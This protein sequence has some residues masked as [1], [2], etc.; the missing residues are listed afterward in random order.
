[1]ST[2]TGSD[3]TDATGYTVNWTR[4]KKV[5]IFIV[6]PLIV[7]VIPAVVV[8]VSLLSG[9]QTSVKASALNSNSIVPSHYNKT[10]QQ[11]L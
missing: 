3:V 4:R 6:I 1:V 8:A 10:V 5:V 7:I 11:L 2:G 9:S